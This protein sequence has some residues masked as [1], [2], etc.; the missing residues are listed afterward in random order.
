VIGPLSPLELMQFI[1]HFML[2]SLLSVGGVISTA[3]EMHRYLVAQNGYLSDS[4]FTT[5]IALAQGAPGPNLLFVPVLG[6]QVAGLGGAMAALAGILLPSTALTLTISRWGH[7]NRES[8][9]VRAFI[10]GF[11]PITICLLLAAAWV[12]VMPFLRHPDYR[13]GALAL[14][15]TTIVLMLTTRIAPIW[16]IAM[17]ATA[18]AIGLI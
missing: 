1:G 13:I 12:V 9:G 3:P 4:D 6:Y 10:Y 14:M 11:A 18:G 17:G 5:S 16:L 2:M 7:K 15:T 8:L